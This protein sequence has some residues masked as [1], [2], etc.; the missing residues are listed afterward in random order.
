MSEAKQTEGGDEQTDDDGGDGGELT[1]TEFFD[2]ISM[3]G[4]TLDGSFYMPAGIGKQRRFFEYDPELVKGF[5]ALRE[6]GDVVAQQVAAH[7]ELEESDGVDQVTKA[8]LEQRVYPK[9]R[10]GFGVFGYAAVESEADEDDGPSGSSGS[11]GYEPIDDDE[12]ETLVREN[13]SEHGFFTEDDGETKV[14]SLAH[15]EARPVGYITGSHV[16]TLPAESVSTV[17]DYRNLVYQALSADAGENKHPLADLD[18]PDDVPIMTD[19]MM[20][21]FKESG[22]K[23]KNDEETRERLSNQVA[24]RWE[25]GEYD[26]LRTSDPDGDDGE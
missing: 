19:D 4:V 13:H 14:V 5:D 21:T 18:S 15:P 23:I 24:A 12:A 25:D 11:G 1:K 16:G 3:E 6:N 8:D 10:D 20:E 22:D 9:L 7:S 17:D 2:R 26:H